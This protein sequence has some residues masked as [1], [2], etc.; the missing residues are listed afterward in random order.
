MSQRV[1]F[2]YD[3]VACTVKCTSCQGTAAG[4]ARLS[5]AMIESSDKKAVVC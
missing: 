2:L 4:L 1:E 5:G 3:V